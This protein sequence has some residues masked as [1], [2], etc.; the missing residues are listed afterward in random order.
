MAPVS[1]GTGLSDMIEVGRSGPVKGSGVKLIG[2][3]TEIKKPPHRVGC[4]GRELT[5]LPIISDGRRARKYYEYAYNPNEA[6]ADS[7]NALIATRAMGKAW[8]GRARHGCA[9]NSVSIP[10]GQGAFCKFSCPGEPRNV[11]EG[12]FIYSNILFLL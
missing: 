12:R 11:G 9:Y 5:Y 3:M 8:L 1:A 7:Q 6:D 4:G 10:V 2:G